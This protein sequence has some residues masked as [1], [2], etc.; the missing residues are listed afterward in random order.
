VGS[1]DSEHDLANEFGFRNLYQ[2]ITRG[3]RGPDYVSFL[4]SI[5]VEAYAAAAKLVKG[6]LLPWPYVLIADKI[7][8]PRV[9]K[10]SETEVDKLALSFNAQNAI[11]NQAYRD[12]VS[13]WKKKAEDEGIPLREF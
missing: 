6:G 8:E 10:A 13:V 5:D 1:I 11:M 9:I 12:A 7:S 3:N 4:V 2:A